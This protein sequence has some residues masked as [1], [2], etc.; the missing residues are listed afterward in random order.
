MNFS[1]YSRVGIIYL[2][3]YT[4][5][6][7]NFQ[8]EYKLDSLPETVRYV[9]RNFQKHI[10]A[11]EAKRK[12]KDKEIEHRLETLNNHNKPKKTDVEKRYISFLA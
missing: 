1:R 3:A 6:W 11:F 9:G 12:N 10:E 4:K 5:I 2:H 7:S 8:K